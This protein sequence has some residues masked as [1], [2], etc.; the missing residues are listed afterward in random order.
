MFI[1]NTHIANIQDEH[2]LSTVRG[3]T[4]ITGNSNAYQNATDHYSFSV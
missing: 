1:L 3:A 4:C 2:K